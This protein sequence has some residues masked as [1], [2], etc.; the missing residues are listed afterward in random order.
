MLSSSQLFNQEID[1]CD[2]FGGYVIS[3][4]ASMFTPDSVLALLMSVSHCIDESI[5]IPHDIRTIEY[6]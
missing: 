4:S 3:S 5:M 1:S 6:T 2:K